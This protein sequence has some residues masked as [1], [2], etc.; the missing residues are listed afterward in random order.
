MKLFYFQYSPKQ[1]PGGLN[2]FGDQLNPWLWQQLIPDLL[3]QDE[4]TAF[5]GIGTLL[6]S[7]LPKRIPNA[8]RIV[9]FSTGLG[10]EELPTVAQSWQIYCLRGPLSAQKL[11]VPKL[12]VTDGGVLVRRLFKPTEPKMHRFAVMPH[13]KSARYGNSVWAS[14]CQQIDFG[15]ID[16]RSPVDS[17]LAA[18][19][20]T[21][22]L[23]TEAMHGAV[24]ADA[25]RVPWIPIMTNPNILAFKWQ[26]WCRS[27]ELEYQPQYVMPWDVYPRAAQGIRS[28]LRYSRYWLNWLKQDRGRSLPQIGK[29]QLVATQLLRIAQTRPHLSRESRLEQLT[30]ELEARL[31]QLRLDVASGAFD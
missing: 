30:V 9:I 24:V 20:Q 17:V 4:R 16:P 31:E 2:N 11:G 27:L 10:Y 7:L 15:Y 21:E 23:L 22:V 14:V 25:L 6:N 1:F 18:I 5:V 19:S 8:Q 3:D 13:A 29:K 12:A 26:D 28:S